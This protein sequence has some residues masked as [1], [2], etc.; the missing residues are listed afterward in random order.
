MAY[1]NRK[2]NMSSE[3]IVDAALRPETQMKQIHR[4]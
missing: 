2:I 1:G 3:S 4:K